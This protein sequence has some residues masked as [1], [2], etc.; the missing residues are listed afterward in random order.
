[1][2]CLEVIDGGLLAGC[3]DGGLRLLPLRDGASFDGKPTLWNAVNGKSSPALTCINSGVA[4]NEWGYQRLI[5][6]TGAEDGSVT[7]FE[8]KKAY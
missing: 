7:L 5:C 3:V 1:M 6:S 4:T 8:L 2:K